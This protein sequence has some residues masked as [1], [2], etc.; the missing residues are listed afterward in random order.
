MQNLTHAYYI[1][2]E[3]KAVKEFMETSGTFLKIEET[4]YET[5]KLKFMHYT[6]EDPWIY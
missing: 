3:F 5:L 2:S 4:R 6:K 1:D